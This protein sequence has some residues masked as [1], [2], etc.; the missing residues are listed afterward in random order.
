MR[1]VIV[2]GLGVGLVAITLTALSCRQGDPVI[3]PKTPPN[4]PLPKIERPD[5]PVVTPK[6]PKDGG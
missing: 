5:D 6:R 2:A 3:D 4:S 1:G